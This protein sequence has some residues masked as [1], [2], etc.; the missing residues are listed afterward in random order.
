VRV[1]VL[2]LTQFSGSASVAA[3]GQPAAEARA[4]SDNPQAVK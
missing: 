3:A 2:N 4:T 1:D